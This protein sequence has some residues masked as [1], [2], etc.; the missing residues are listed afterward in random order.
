MA[1]FVIML[2]SGTM[3]DYSFPSND[4]E[5][6]E[7]LLDLIGSHWLNVYDGNQLVSKYLEARA[8]EE[9]QTAS[10]AQEMV[11]SLSHQNVPVFHKDHWHVL[12][13][14]E[15]ELTEVPLTYGEGATYGQGYLYGY[16]TGRS[17]YHFPVDDSLRRVPQI[18]NR[19]TDPSLSYTYGV[20]FKIANGEIVFN[21]NPFANALFATAAVYDGDTVVD[22]EIQLWLFQ[23]EWDMAHIYTYFGY[24]LNLELESSQAYKDAVSTIF[25]AYNSGTS[26]RHF[27]QA[28]SALSG[29]QCVIEDEETVEVITTDSRWTLVITDKNVYKFNLGVVVNVSV[30]DTVYGG[31]FLCD[32]IKIYELNDGSVPADLLAIQL[33]EGILGNGYLEGL[34]FENKTVDLDV[35]TSGDYTKVSFEIGGFPTDVD[36]FW[37]EV[38]ERGVAAGQTLA[39]LLDVRTNPPDEPAAASL[40]STINP[41]EFLAENFLRFNT[42]VVKIKSNQANG[43]IGLSNLRILRRI[44]PPWTAVIVLFELGIDNETLSLAVTGDSETFGFDESAS[45]A[46]AGDLMSETWS[47]PSMFSEAP[48]LRRVGGICQ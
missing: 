14:K 38:H 46:I 37:N 44:V 47:F 26:L 10:D 12:T 1:F 18:F 39:H 36:A 34:T 42:Y 41:L 17:T 9:T 30:G 6:P 28:L 40:P 20:E 13:I 16:T 7:I 4:F 33:N 2:K 32:A 45:A 3:T 15:S 35:D 31:Q 27:Q 23:S 29:V 25:A 48:T 43:G 22:R 19:I 24:L 8:L 5:K 11:D 21:D